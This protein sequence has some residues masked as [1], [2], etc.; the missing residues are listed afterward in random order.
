MSTNNKSKATKASTG[1]GVAGNNRSMQPFLSGTK[2]AP[3]DGSMNIDIDIVV[4][5]RNDMLWAPDRFI[6]TMATVTR[7]YNTLFSHEDISSAIPLV[8]SHSL[9]LQQQQELMDTKLK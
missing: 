8:G 4:L 9:Q 1:N 2:Q 7:Y 5:L 3:Q 6:S